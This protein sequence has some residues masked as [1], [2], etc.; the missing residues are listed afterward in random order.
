MHHRTHNGFEP[1]KV[2][3][4]GLCRHDAAAG[5]LDKIDS[6][7]QVMGGGH[8]VVNTVDLLA[9]VDSDDVGTFFG[10]ADSMRTT[11]SARS[12]GD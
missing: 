2:S 5:L 3:D 8:W 9:D 1:L 11:L 7:F 4:I 6:F 12:T 10:K